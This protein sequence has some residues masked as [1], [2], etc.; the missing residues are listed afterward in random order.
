MARSIG[1]KSQLP[2][3]ITC[4]VVMSLGCVAKVTAVRSVRSHGV[5]IPIAAKNRRLSTGFGQGWPQAI[6]VGDAQRPWRVPADAGQCEAGDEPPEQRPVLSRLARPRKR[7]PKPERGAGSAD[8]A[9]Q[10]S[11]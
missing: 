6:A 7:G 1:A 8:A 11:P 9:P 10:A 2:P 3:T 5:Q 4:D